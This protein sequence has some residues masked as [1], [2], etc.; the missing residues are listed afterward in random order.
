MIGLTLGLA[1]LQGVVLLTPI[2][3][4]PDRVIEPEAAARTFL[5][6]CWR[7]LRTPER[8]R[9]A[10]QASPLQFAPAPTRHAGERYRSDRADIHYVLEPPF[11][12]YERPIC[13]MSIRLAREEEATR[14]IA[15]LTEKLGLAAPESGTMLDVGTTVYSWRDVPIDDRAYHLTA[16]A[17]IAANGRRPVVLELSLSFENRMG[18]P[19]E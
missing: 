19:A 16:E 18:L 9:A 11:A 12:G 17:D 13:T 5:T 14:F 6:T 3:A 8:F 2:D 15:R 1:L 10:I 7:G 4:F